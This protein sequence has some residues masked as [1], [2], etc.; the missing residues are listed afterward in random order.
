MLFSE[1]SD[2]L[3]QIEQVS[4]RLEITR[5]LSK[6]LEKL[7]AQEAHIA[8]Y[9]LLGELRPAHDSLEFNLSSKM[10]I[11]A[12]AR[13]SPEQAATEALGE[14]LSLFAANEAS[15]AIAT[16][17]EKNVERLYKQKGDIGEVGQ[18]VVA[19]YLE[20]LKK[21]TAHSKSTLQ[22]TYTELVQLA[23]ESGT[24]SQEKKLVL[25][26]EMLKKLD[27]VSARFI[28]RMV[29]GKMRLGFSTMT[30]LDALSWSVFGNKSASKVLETGWQKKADEGELLDH[31][32]SAHRKLPLTSLADLEKLLA[33]Y[34]VAVGIPVVP[35]LCQRLPTPKEVIEKLGKVI[36]EPKYDGLRV[37][38]H[39]SKKGAKTTIKAFSRSLEDLTHMFPELVK[40]AEEVNAESVILDS[41]AIGIDTTTGEL[42]PFQETITRK[43][44]HGV[45]DKAADIPIKFFVYDVLSL[46][47]ED[48]L[49]TPLSER[50]K[51]LKTIF[52]E[53]SVLSQ[54]PFIVT[55]DPEE[56]DAFHTD[57][58]AHGLEGAVV[59]QIE[60]P[61]QSGRKGWYWVKMKEKAGEF[62]K[63]TDT[64]DCVVLGYY[65][66]RGKRTQFGLGAVLVGIIDADETNPNRI[67]TLAKIG[68]GM[69][70]DQLT[71]MK[72]RLD[73][74]AVKNQPSD[75]VVAKALAP[76]IWVA[77]AVVIEVAADEITISPLHSA[78][79]ALR[80]PRLVKF[81]DDKKWDQAT[82][83]LELE[84]IQVAG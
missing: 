26:S 25:L 22:E 75:Y 6:L 37:Q 20:S 33:H 64:V 7:S 47:G 58:L 41:E 61:Y 13:L 31:V 15:D 63:L 66:G 45:D 50:K 80:F 17:K 38:I 43:R 16:E 55:E 5:I 18:E 40:V 77:P 29:V 28:C 42:R 39:I 9:L 79:K 24:G 4:A 72:S 71:E 56:L 83:K 76:D 81:R 69:T 46:N 59:K 19:H 48:L 82:T 52:K 34:A 8:S 21:N 44:K 1:F 84:S 74:H 68:T 67:T 27:P 36:A 49:L 51:I 32:L 73:K 30:L 3:K 60:S 12:L 11:R 57:Q 53:S 35:Q 65:G 70:E 10:V 23:Q 54:A 14:S 78:G 62:G 2:Y